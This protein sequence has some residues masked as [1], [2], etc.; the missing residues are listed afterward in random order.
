MPPLSKNKSPLGG[1]LIIMNKKSYLIATFAILITAAFIYSKAVFFDYVWD[2]TTLFLDNSTLRNPTDLW[3]AISKSILPGTTYFRPAVLISFIIEFQFLGVNPAYS[4]LINILILLTNTLLIGALASSIWHGHSQ[5]KKHKVSFLAMAIYCFHPSLIESTVWVA[6]RFDLLC[7]TFYLLAILAFYR[8][9][10]ITRNIA[11]GLFFFLALCSKEMAITLPIAILILALAEESKLQL[12]TLPTVIKEKRLLILSLVISLFSYLAIRY[13]VHPE[14]YVANQTLQKELSPTQ[15]LSLISYTLE[16]Y[17]RM[18]VIPFLDISP[19]HPFDIGKKST[20]QNVA[21]IVGLAL[22]ISFVIVKIVKKPSI[23]IFLFAIY[24]IS[25][26]PVLNILPLNIGGN[27]GHERFLAIPLI[28]ASILTSYIIIDFASKL[29]TATFLLIG[30]WICIAIAT[31]ATTIPLWKNEFSLWYWAYE[32]YPNMK[33]VQ[34]NYLSSAIFMGQ[35]ETAEKFL[36]SIKR[37]QKDIGRLKAA[38]GQL[39]VRQGHYDQAINTLNEYL[40]DEYQPH[41]EVEARGIPLSQA[42]ILRDNFQNAWLLRYIY[43][44]LAEAYLKSGQY[45]KALANLDIVEFYGPGYPVISLMRSLAEYGL[46]NTKMGDEQ[47]ERAKEEFAP[48][49]IPQVKKAREDFLNSH[50]NQSSEAFEKI[51]KSAPLN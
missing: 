11:T 25:L 15:T 22:F 14:L 8:L 36:E 51:M 19:M 46:G 6:G 16:F 29:K 20:L 39:L 7:T 42:R 33:F 13:Q 18:T 24:L 35:L 27:I 49:F 44:S 38:E 32:K 37:E 23:S 12:R 30:G 1:F 26:T 28:F 17:I 45:T 3:E 9:K 5:A 34:F 50:Q 43:G 41:L 2:D 47:F 4:H 31:T 40:R 21:S 48:E 10:G